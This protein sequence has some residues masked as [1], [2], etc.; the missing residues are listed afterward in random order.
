MNP[1]MCPT[2]S[3]S[4]RIQGIFVMGVAWG[5][6]YYMICLI[7]MFIRLHKCLCSSG[8]T[9]LEMMIML[10]ILIIIATLYLEPKPSFTQPLRRTQGESDWNRYYKG[11]FPKNQHHYE[12]KGEGVRAI[13]TIFGINFQPYVL[14]TIS[15][16]STCSLIVL[17]VLLKNI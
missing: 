10:M 12:A 17:L 9:L 8:R 2:A 5:S 11:P 13:Y 15:L 1:V 14:A 16:E 3:Y 6:I 7:C 4:S